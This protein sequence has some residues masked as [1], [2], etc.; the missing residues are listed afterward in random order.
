MSTLYN[1]QLELYNQMISQTSDNY[2]YNTFSYPLIYAD[3]KK[4]TYAYPSKNGIIS[5]TY[6]HLNNDKK[7]IKT[8]SKYYYYKIL[9]KWLYKDLLAL[10][11]FIN[12]VDGKAKLITSL[13]DYDGRKLVSDSSQDVKNKIKYMEEVIITKDI[14]KHVLKKI[15]SKYN[16]DWAQL[17][18][19]E[20]KIKKYFFKYLK[21]KLKEA[22]S[23]VK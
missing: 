1:Y 13:N 2:D 4:T 3:D 22:I 7:T 23:D 6:K 21:D 17:E 5:Y 11:G 14:V 18:D 19:H 12:I 8:I 20:D 10:L 15:V 9:D 16:I